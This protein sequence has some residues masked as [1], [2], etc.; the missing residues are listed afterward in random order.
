MQLSP[1][2]VLAL[3]GL[4]A[5]HP[6]ISDEIVCLFRHEFEPIVQSAGR[7]LT[8]SLRPTTN[9][10]LDLLFDARADFRPVRKCGFVILGEASGAVMIEAHRALAGCTTDPRTQRILRRRVLTYDVLLGRALFNTAMHELGHIVAALP[11]ISDPGNYM[12]SG[13]PPVPMRT[14]S[15]RREFSAGPKRFTEEQRR[16][17]VEQIQ[18]GTWLYGGED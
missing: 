7:S 4:E 16:R 8:I 2:L 11:D 12:V 9:G 15:G 13:D 1:R 18:L 6:R 5:L 10:D 3:H 17:M 14:R